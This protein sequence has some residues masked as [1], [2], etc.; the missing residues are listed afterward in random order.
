M[1]YQEGQKIKA[2]YNASVYKANI[3]GWRS[4]K[5]EAVLEILPG[6]KK[7]KVLDCKME[8]AGFRRSWYNVIGAQNKE[9]GNIKMITSLWNIEVLE[10]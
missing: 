1:T 10:E 8:P 6:G 5:V 9:I 7:A 4:E 3:G 2:C